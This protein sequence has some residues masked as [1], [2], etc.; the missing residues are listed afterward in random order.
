MSGYFSFS[1]LLNLKTKLEFCTSNIL[2]ICYQKYAS[3]EFDML[4]NGVKHLK[5]CNRRTPP[6]F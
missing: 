3:Y 4:I 2:N 1:S 6:E 5:V